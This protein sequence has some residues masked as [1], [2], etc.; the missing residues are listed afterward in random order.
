MTQG[1][2]PSSTRRRTFSAVGPC[3]SARSNI[4]VPLVPGNRKE[5]CVVAHPTHSSGL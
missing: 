2:V 1:R 5:R 4:D 3:L